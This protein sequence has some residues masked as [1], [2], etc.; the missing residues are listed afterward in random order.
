LAS[1]T[2]LLLLEKIASFV[3]YEVVIKA[4]GRIW[5]GGAGEKVG[6]KL[7]A[8]KLLMQVLHARIGTRSASDAASPAAEVTSTGTGAVILLA[9]AGNLTFASV[10]F[11]SGK[12]IPPINYNGFAATIE[13]VRRKPKKQRKDN[14]D[15]NDDEDDQQQQRRNKQ[16]GSGRRREGGG[17]RRKETSGRVQG[18]RPTLA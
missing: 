9:D 5:E 17:G 7:R 15:E 18:L 6:K 12:V 4:R 3:V 14:D 1:G 8:G 16:R 10:I 2:V 11:R 13:F